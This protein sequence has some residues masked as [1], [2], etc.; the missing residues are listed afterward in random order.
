MTQ[1]GTCPK[2]KKHMFSD[3]ASESNGLIPLTIE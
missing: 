2:A 1:R 3:S